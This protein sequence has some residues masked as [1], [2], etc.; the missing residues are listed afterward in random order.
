MPFINKIEARAYSRATE[1][2]DRVI[3]S[4]RSIFPENIR[5]NVSVSEEQVEGQSGDSISIVSG[6]L[7]SREDCETTFDYILKKLEKSDRSAIRRS[8]DLRLNRNC[9]FFL[10][11]DKQG[12]FLEKM[13]L[14][15]DADVIRARF[16]F[17]DSPRCKKKD[18]IILINKRLQDAEE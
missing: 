6:L 15:N 1:I 14:A 9:V 16:Y 17:R 4:I 3:I 11:I 2:S 7:T 8:L 13:R 10:R 18:A 12:A 5:Q